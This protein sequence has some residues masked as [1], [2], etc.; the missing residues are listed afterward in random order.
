MKEEQFRQQVRGIARTYGWDLQYHTHDSRRSDA[1]WP[2]EVLINTKR[3]R[4]IFV[5]LKNEKGKVTPTQQKWIHALQACGLEAD[6]WRPQDMHRIIAT[7]GPQQLPLYPPLQSP[8]PENEEP[9]PDGW[10][11]QGEMGE[12]PV[13]P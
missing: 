6:V 4:I 13:Y 12:H 3:G 5:E 7:L 1:G 2:D 11:F 10:Y 8:M 9:E